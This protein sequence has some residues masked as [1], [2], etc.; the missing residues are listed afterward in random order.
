[1][2]VEKESCNS[3]GKTVYPTE[4]VAA[5]GQVFHKACFRCT[6]C[7]NVL[8]LGSFASMGGVF[9]CKPHFKQ[10]FATKGSLFVTSYFVVYFFQVVSI[11]RKTILK[12]TFLFQEITVKDLVI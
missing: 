8:K 2:S 7:K 4:K 10:L 11:L 6:H 12:L 9:Y 5:D 1:M 3:C